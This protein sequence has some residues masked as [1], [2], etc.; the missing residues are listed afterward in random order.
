M[1][2][3]VKESASDTLLWQSQEITFQ[4]WGP[5]M[6][7]TIKICVGWQLLLSFESPCLFFGGEEEEL[8]VSDK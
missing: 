6:F 2:D 1:S 3:R 7:I 4:T 8:I 5:I